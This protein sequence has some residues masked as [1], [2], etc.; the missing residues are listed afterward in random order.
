MYPNSFVFSFPWYKKKFQRPSK[1][2]TVNIFHKTTRIC[3]V[4]KNIIKAYFPSYR[5]QSIDLQSKLIN[6]FLY[7]RN[8]VLVTYQRG[9]NKTSYTNFF[10]R[11]N[12]LHVTRGQMKKTIK[13][14]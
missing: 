10:R 14:N 9:A 6:W 1:T 12:I 11:W 7:D 13:Q 2:Q 8:V 5:N 3:N 4:S